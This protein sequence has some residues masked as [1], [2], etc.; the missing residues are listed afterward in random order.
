MTDSI[1]LPARVIL[2]GQAI[3]PLCATLSHALQRPASLSGETFQGLDDVSRHLDS[4]TRGLEDLGEMLTAINTSVLGNEQASDADVYRTAGRLEQAL[5]QLIRPYSE[6]GSSTPQSD[7]PELQPLILGVFRHTLTEIH[8]WLQSM[9]KDIQYPASACKRRRLKV[10][11]GM[12]LSIELNLSSPPEMDRLQQIADSIRSAA[13][14]ALDN[15]SA[16]CPPP[17]RPGLMAHLGGLLFG[18][19]VVSRHRPH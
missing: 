10:T 1:E 12:V 17:P 9:V 7:A 18:L 4:Y 6:I 16:P 2:W 13:E 5:Q 3:R 15:G 11:E 8:D 14:Q 19:A